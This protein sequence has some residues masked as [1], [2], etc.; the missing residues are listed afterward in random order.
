MRAVSGPCQ[1]SQHSV[2]A[3]NSPSVLYWLTRYISPANKR[4]C[5]IVSW[6]VSGPHL[7]PLLDSPANKPGG[8]ML[9]MARNLL[10]YYQ[11]FPATVSNSGACTTV[12]CSCSFVSHL[13]V[14]RPHV[15]GFPLSLRMLLFLQSI[16]YRLCRNRGLKLINCQRFTLRTFPLNE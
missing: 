13:F 1:D 6:L 14:V 4:K 10:C 7:A 11:L 15:W 9:H 3:V 12:L 2:I 5:G 8:D 16:I